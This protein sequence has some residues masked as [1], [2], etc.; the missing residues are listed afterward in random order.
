MCL[1]KKKSHATQG[2]TRAAKTGA[3]FLLIFYLF[4]VRQSKKDKKKGRLAMLDR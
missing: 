1:S 3:I 2:T 4:N